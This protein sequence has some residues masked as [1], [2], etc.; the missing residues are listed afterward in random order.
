MSPTT[1]TRS[2]RSAWAGVDIDALKVS[3]EVAWYMES[4]GFDPPT[5]PP[6]IKTP[7]PTD[8]GAVFDA[9]AVD[10]VLGTFHRL[11]HTQGEWY[12]RPLDPD[13]WQVAY[14]IAP[15]FGWKQPGDSGELVR[16]FRKAYVEVPRKNG[17]TTMAGGILLYL[18]FAD[19]EMGAQVVCAATGEKQARFAFDPIRKLST[20][21]P[22][23]KPHVR[24]FKQRVVHL[25]SSSYIEVVSSS[26]EAQHGANLHGALVDEL[27]VH[28]TPDLVEAI[29]TGTGARRQPLIFIITTA[30]DSRHETIYDRRHRYV[31]QVANGS[32]RDLT[33][34]GAIWYA[35]E[36]DDPFDESTWAKANPGYPIAPTR[37][38]MRSASSEAQQSPAELSKFLRLHLNVRTKQDVRFLDMADWD[39]CA[40]IPPEWDDLAGRV[41][42]GGIDLANTHD[43]CAVAWA[44]PD[45]HRG[46]FD[47]VWRFYMPEEGMADLSKRTHGAADVWASQ[48][49]LTVTPGNVSDYDFI[50]ADVM[51]DAEHFVVGGIGIDRWNATQLAVQLGNEGLPVVLKPQSTVAMNDAT[52]ELAR[53]LRGSRPDAPLLRHGGHPV[54]RWNADNFAV[55]LDGEGNVKP[56]KTRAADRI[57]GVVALIMALDR[58][59]IAE[60][61]SG[62]SITLV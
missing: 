58:A 20:E 16:V 18:A 50:K 35:E 57:D 49:F 21:S 41:A 61:G 2:A 3:P 28:K 34:Y 38:Y 43:L 15:I 13:P 8:R 36:G 32:I 30:D 17:K 53:L 12:G 4:R 45:T 46:G 26:A 48:G 29:E 23:L 19:G 24:V 37:A 14:V 60:P 47:V 39:S 22:S 33:Q 5:S 1:T 31:E 51:R 62:P 44:L 59:M 40:G 56:A 52:R 42:Y 7:E 9:E 27:H 54:A 10:R 55:Q 25:R 11:R 6:Q